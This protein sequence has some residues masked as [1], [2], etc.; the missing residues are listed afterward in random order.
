MSERLDAIEE[1]LAFLERAVNEL[2]DVVARQQR[3]LQLA[4][5]R[6]RL[7][8]EKLAAAESDFGPS[9]TAYEKPPHY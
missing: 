9:A 2:S 7:L 4:H 6:N 3:E 8:M 1:K 5:E